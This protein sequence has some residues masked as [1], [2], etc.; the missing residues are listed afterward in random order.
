MALGVQ[1][2]DGVTLV[3]M[4]ADAA[5]AVAALE[6]ALR[7]DHAAKPPKSAVAWSP[8]TTPPA[9]PSKFP[10]D[11]RIIRGVVA[12]RGIAVGR[13]TH[14]TR[15]EPVVSEAGAGVPR[16]NAELTRA[17]AAVRSRIEAL[18]ATA[19]DATREVLEAHLTFIDDTSLVDSAHAWIARGKSAGFAWRQAVSE[20]VAEL[21]GVGD[22]RV[23][24][25]FLELVREEQ[26]V[27]A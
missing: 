26:G 14:L 18:A 21:R 15:P 13:A 1:R 6:S 10:S 16:E 19:R 5:A 25:M 27:R 24:E 4:G 7:A 3:A 2:G 9:T 23:H 20:S 11:D 12:S 17:R 22:T 8:V